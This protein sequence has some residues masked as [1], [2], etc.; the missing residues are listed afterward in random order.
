[1]ADASDLTEALRPVVAE[2]DRLGVRYCVGGSIASSMHGAARSTLDVDLAAELDE[3]SA[4]R[5]TAALSDQYY[6]SESAAREAVRHR[7]CFNLL[8]YATAF[9]IDIFISRGTDFDRQVQDR[10]MADSLGGPNGLPARIVSAE[11]IILIK[12]EWYRLGD[13]SSER[14]WNDVT[15]VAKLQGSR[16]DRPYLR[17]WAKEL[18]VAD[19]LDRLFSEV[20]PALGL[21]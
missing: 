2:L 15:Q 6:I 10:A 21:D 7:S 9:K 20:E 4:L 1:M 13:E 11:D 17:H 3:A 12:L 8:H 18:G 16:L 19:L 5:L 14:Q